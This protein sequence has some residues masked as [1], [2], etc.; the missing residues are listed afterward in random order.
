MAQA[1]LLSARKMQ[2]IVH[3]QADAQHVA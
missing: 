3:A 1:G 2:G